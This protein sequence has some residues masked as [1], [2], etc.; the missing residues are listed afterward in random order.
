MLEYVFNFSDVFVFSKIS[1]VSNFYFHWTV[2]CIQYAYSN[3]YSYIFLLFY[4]Y[5]ISIFKQA[6]WTIMGSILKKVYMLPKIMYTILERGGISFI[7]IWIHIIYMNTY[8][9]GMTLLWYFF[10][11]LLVKLIISLQR[12]SLTILCYDCVS[13][14]LIFYLQAF[15]F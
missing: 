5:L 11:V 1:S 12:W 7:C 9:S 13:L 2:V 10:M 14:Y 4:N 3:F 8:I 15:L 6:L